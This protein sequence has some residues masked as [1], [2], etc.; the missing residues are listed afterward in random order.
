MISYISIIRTIKDAGLKIEYNNTLNNQNYLTNIT[1]LNKLMLTKDATITSNVIINV[2]IIATLTI[3]ITITI[4]STVSCTTIKDAGLKITY[5]INI[6]YV[7]HKQQDTEQLL[8][9]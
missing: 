7:N 4:N 1:Q 5:Y 6:T 9:K 3:T 2:D 8:M